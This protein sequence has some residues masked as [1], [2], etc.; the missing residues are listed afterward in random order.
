M[1]LGMFSDS[2]ISGATK[3]TRLAL[4]RKDFLARR[5]QRTHD[6]LQGL[7]DKQKQAEGLAKESYWSL[8]RRQMIL[9]KKERKMSA[10]FKIQG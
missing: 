5:H 4:A 6:R 1:H 3:K 8:E 10:V 9:Q 7:I 2:T